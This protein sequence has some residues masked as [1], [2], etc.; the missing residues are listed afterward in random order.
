MAKTQSVDVAMSPRIQMQFRKL[1]TEKIQA[2]LSEVAEGHSATA[3]VQL[4]QQLVGRLSRMDA[5]QHQAMAVA[6][7]QRRSVEIQQLK[8]ALQ[9]IKDDE[10]GYCEDCGEDIAQ[11]RLKIN[12]TTTRC[13]SCA[14]G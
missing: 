8:L 9:R 7:N 4:D 2:L 10:F 13:I 14:S 1:I 3:V 6:A 12:P 11:E 5:L